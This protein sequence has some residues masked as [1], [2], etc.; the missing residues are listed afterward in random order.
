MIRIDFKVEGDNV[1]T[2]WVREDGN[3]H[4]M[5]GRLIFTQDDFKLLNRKLSAPDGPDELNAS[6]YWFVNKF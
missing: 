1:L 4:S 6:S 3:S 2:T 5:M